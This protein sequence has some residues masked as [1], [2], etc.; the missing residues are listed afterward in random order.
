MNVIYSNPFGTFIN[1]F[2]NGKMHR[3]N[4]GDE[5]IAM[6]LHRKVELAKQ[7]PTQEAIDEIMEALNKNYRVARLGGLELDPLTEQV[8]L[9]GYNTPMPEALVDRIE[10]YADNG[11]PV[12]ALHNFWKLLMANPD[13]RVREDLFDFINHNGFVITDNGYFI[14]YKSVALKSDMDT[15]L[16][17]FVTNQYVHV[18][19]NWSK[20]PLKYTVYKDL[21]TE[22]YAITK[23][24]TF[25]GWDLDEKEIEYV[26]ILGEL[27]DDIDNLIDDSEVVYT[28]HHTKEMEIRLGV[29]V[30]Q[31]RGSCDADPKRDC[32]SG[33]HVG[34]TS[35]VESFGHRGCPVLICL[36]NPMNVV[37][38]PDYDHSKMRVCEY[39]PM[40]LATRDEEGTID[41][42]EQEYFESDYISHEE[43]VLEE[44]LEQINA[45]EEVTN[46]ASPMNADVDE[47]EL[48]EVKKIIANRLV[49]IREVEIEE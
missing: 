20:S 27:F 42:I 45:E 15:D 12:T 4:F 9:T 5:S 39:Y 3:K 25:E 23:N 18:R 44:I 29:P 31:E 26:G 41:V 2:I 10:T 11:F 21:N 40:A 37:A 6:E 22:E 8:F 38:V 46:F 33:L 43:K 47:R 48:E 35:Y 28:D 17:T 7:N 49:N 24:E 13:R 1:V 19:K 34:A 14:T 36:V 16:V 32:S 30:K